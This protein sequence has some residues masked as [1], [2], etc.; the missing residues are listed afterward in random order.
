MVM[1]EQARRLSQPLHWGRREKTIVAVL[2]GCLALAVAGLAVYGLTNSTPAR[3]DCIDVTFASTLGGADLRGCG[4]Q[5][6]E[7]C[8][9]GHQFRSIQPELRAACRRA[10]FAFGS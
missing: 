2:L 3:A 4:P 10:G 1:Q 6:K 5:A 7:I 9:A 8:A